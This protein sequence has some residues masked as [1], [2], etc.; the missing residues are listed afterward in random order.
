MEAWAGACLGTGLGKGLGGTLETDNGLLNG[1]VLGLLLGGRTREYAWWLRRVDARR[2]ARM[3]LKDSFGTDDGLLDGEV[4]GLLL[5]ERT[6][7]NAWWRRKS[8]AWANRRK[9]SVELGFKF[10]ALGEGE[11]I[12][13]VLMALGKELEEALGTDD[14]LRLGKVLAWTITRRKETRQHAW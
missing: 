14:G 13:W 10:E 4:L 7:E 8:G 9:E 6:R 1:K 2:R 3:E 11:K 5:G 12:R